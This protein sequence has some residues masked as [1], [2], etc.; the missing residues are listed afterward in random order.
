M[1]GYLTHIIF[2]HKILPA[3]L[4]NVKMYNLGLMGPDIFYYEKSDPKYKIIADTLHEIDSTNLI[5]KLKQESKEYALGFYLHNYLDKKIHPRIT[6]LERTTNK[7][8]TKI[9]TIIDAALL[10]KEWNI[11]V[12]KLDKNFFPQR[13]PAGFVRIFE[14]E[15]YR[16]FGIEDVHLKDIYH[17]FLKNFSLLYEFYY[18]KAVLVYIMYLITFGNFN[19]KDYYIFKTP[20]VDILKDYGIEVLWKEAIKEV[21]PLIKDFF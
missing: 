13:I 4:K 9:E 12:A 14:E 17:T 8:H 18:L 16:S 11:S 15:L 5:M 10:K 19:Y 2:G 6:T 21:V 3:N 7:S 1:P 20:S